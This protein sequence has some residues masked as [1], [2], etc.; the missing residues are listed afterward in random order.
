[1]SP[2]PNDLLAWQL[3][4]GCHDST[5]LKDPRNGSEN[6]PGVLHQEFAISGGN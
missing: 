4:L 3:H 1:M 6:G 5:Q 2:N